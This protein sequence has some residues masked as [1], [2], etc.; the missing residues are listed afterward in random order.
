MKNVQLVIPMAGSSD[1]FIDA[2][3]D[4]PKWLIDI[5]GKPM[6]QHVVDQ[7][8]EVNDILFICKEEDVQDLANLQKLES[9][10]GKVVTIKQSSGGPLD[11]ILQASEHISDD[12]EI[13]VSYCDHGMVWDCSSFLEEAR[14]GNFDG[15]MTC[16]R[17]FHPHMLETTNLY[18][19]CLQENNKLL[20]VQDKEPFTED[21][22]SQFVSSD[23]FYFKTGSVLKKYCEAAT[24]DSSMNGFVASV[25][26][27]LVK[28][29]LSVYVH[30]VDKML[31]WATPED[32]EIY[33][34]WSNY[35]NQKSVDKAPKQ[36]FTVIVPMCGKGSRFVKEGY[37][38][39]KPLLPI[40]ESPMFAGV[41]D[42][43]PKHEN[44]VFICSKDQDA[45][46]LI[47]SYYPKAKVKSIDFITE[48]FAES[49]ELAIDLIDK[50]DPILISPCDNGVS[51]DE[52]MF[53]RM[54]A[55][56]DNDVIFWVT[57]GSQATRVNPAMYTWVPVDDDNY[58]LDMVY[59]QKPDSDLKT[60]PVSIGIMYFRKAKYLLDGLYKN[61]DQNIRPTGEL[62]MD[63]VAH[64]L[65]KSNYKV[66]VFEVD[67]YACWGTP[68][69]YESYNFWRKYFD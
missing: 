39:P 57:T 42:C 13:I 25:Y 56:E 34:R 35:F 8:P 44:N 33:K 26:N 14:C 37:E 51:Y 27:L 24:Q 54:V 30:A 65:A 22:K 41:V 32:M 36:D 3:Y 55:D 59:K 31:L 16:Y 53:L 5:D 15:A 60:T 64:Q 61:R 58:I 69:D 45:D 19:F 23:V 68:D 50:E 28:D 18:T 40:G 63:S 12:K 38:L 62:C 29:N 20:E 43:L 10:G 47:R 17:N 7:F 48:G 6:L 4:S 67:H 46:D 1:M 21:R 2:G 49:C 9:L 11:T 52:E 66:K